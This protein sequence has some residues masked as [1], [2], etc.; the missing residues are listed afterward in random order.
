[1]LRELCGEDTLK[2]VVI[3]TNRWEDVATD[4]GDA[5]ER[6][7]RTKE[8]FFKLALDK[9]ARMVRHH[10][11]Y[12]SAS[13]IVKGL[14]SNTPLPLLIQREMINEGKQ[15]LDTAAGEVV[16]H[17][18]LEVIRKHT[19]ELDKIKEEMKGQCPLHRNVS[20]TY[21]RYTSSCYNEG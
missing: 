17:E 13:A 3:V 6:E 8:I 9:G 10:N 21:V 20:P 18:L 5:R 16:N 4:L 19:A 1:M 7:L 14:I 11:T 15:L 12:E 2:N